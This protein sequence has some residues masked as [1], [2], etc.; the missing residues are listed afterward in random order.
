MLP[1]VVMAVARRSGTVTSPRAAM[2]RYTRRLE[3][4]VWEHM[5]RLGEGGYGC[6]WDD[7]STFDDWAVNGL[8][9]NVAWCG[10]GGGST[11]RQRYHLPR[12]N[13]P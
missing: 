4:F 9:A 6:G 7:S 12:C 2:Y 13:V 1:A 3:E 10:C 8:A 5:R 11:L